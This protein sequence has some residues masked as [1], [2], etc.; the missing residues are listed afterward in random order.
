MFIRIQ[1]N[2]AKLR[3]VITLFGGNSQTSEFLVALR[4]LPKERFTFYVAYAS[5]DKE[6]KNNKLLET[7]KNH[8]EITE[9]EFNSKV[10]EI[11]YSW[12]AGNRNV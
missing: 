8:K 5:V 2:R 4:P 7:I 1:T 9:L 3:E 12:T 11:K 10:S 6:S